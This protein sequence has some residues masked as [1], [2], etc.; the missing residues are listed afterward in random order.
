MDDRATIGAPG[1][2]VPRRGATVLVADRH[3]ATRATVSGA[4]E[5]A[6]FR[7][8]RP[9]R[10]AA[11]AV[12]E[13]ARSR[14]DVCLVDVDLPGGGLTAVRALASQRSTMRIVV[15]ASAA[16]P[17]DLFAAVRAGAVGYVLKDIDPARLP[18]E[19][20]AVL[21]GEAALSR[22]LTA[23][24]IAEFRDLTARAVASGRQTPG[25]TDRRRSTE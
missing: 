24:L 3:T 17:D 22:D 2:G 12:A 7:V 16:R 11:A 8:C 4:L 25:T 19:V 14:P 15:L 13:A 18:G 20:D 9:C 6:G 5:R 10:D 21:A 23:R 1:P